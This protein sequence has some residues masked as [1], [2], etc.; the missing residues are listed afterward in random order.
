VLLEQGQ[1]E[2]LLLLPEAAL[3]FRVLLEQGLLALL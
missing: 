2:Q 3:R 1:L